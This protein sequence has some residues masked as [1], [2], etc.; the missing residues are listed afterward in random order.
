MDTDGVTA[1]A[2]ALINSKAQSVTELDLSDNQFSEVEAATALAHTIIG[3]GLRV[4]RLN[5]NALGDACVSELADALNPKVSPPRGPALQLLELASCQIGISGAKCLLQCIRH[6]EILMC[7]KLSDNFLDDNLEVTLVES[8]EF[9][10][11]LRLDSNRLSRRFLSRAAQMCSRNIHIMRDQVPRELRK[12]VSRLLA[13]EARLEEARKKVGA[14]EAEIFIRVSSTNK[15]VEDTKDL[16]AAI[17]KSTKLHS[18]K[19]AALEETLIQRRQDLERVKEAIT[20]AAKLNEVANRDLKEEFKQR[21]AELAEYTVQAEEIRK[22]LEQRQEEHP[23]E[24]QQLRSK[25]DAATA[26]TEVLRVT[27]D[28]DMRTQLKSVQHRS[29]IDFKP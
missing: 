11:D 12:E 17:A 1:L 9:I 29:L 22:Q 16:R 3:T 25:I 13:Q 5:G 20:E 27:A 10:Q 6:N 19:I 26:A 14:D 24:V 7:L 21:E 23:K 15:L 18:Q 4:L 2:D 28:D 8:L